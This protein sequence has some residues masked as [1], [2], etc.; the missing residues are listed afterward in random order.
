MIMLLQ[1]HKVIYC[2]DQFNNLHDSLKMRVSPYSYQFVV[3]IFHLFEAGIATAI[4]S[5]K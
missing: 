1:K 3:S 4:S 5:F 2:L